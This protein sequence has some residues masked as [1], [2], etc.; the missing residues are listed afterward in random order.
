MATRCCKRLLAGDLSAL[1]HIGA[2]G[3]SYARGLLYDLRGGRGPEGR[4]AA[5]FEPT[6][7]A[8]S[9]TLSYN[10]SLSVAAPWL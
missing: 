7:C 1:L 5:S 8:R 2:S 4:A 9:P 3:E 6:T 10:S